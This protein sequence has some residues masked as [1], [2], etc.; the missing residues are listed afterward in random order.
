MLDVGQL[1]GERFGKEGLA[2]LAAAERRKNVR[3]KEICLWNSASADGGVS[4][5]IGQRKVQ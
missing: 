1:A 4:E 2:L 5:P 3:P